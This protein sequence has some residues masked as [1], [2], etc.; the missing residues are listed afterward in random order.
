[1][2]GTRFQNAALPNS[3]AHFLPLPSADYPLQCSHTTLS[4]VPHKP[5]I[6][7]LVMSA[8]R[9]SKESRGGPACILNHRGTISLMHHPQW[10][11][12]P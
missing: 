7:F 3:Q 10:P 4:A 9:C 2:D 1:M 8:L 12:I 11:Y 6:L 5:H